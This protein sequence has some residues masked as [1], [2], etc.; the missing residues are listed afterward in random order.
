MLLFILV[1][2]WVRVSEISTNCATDPEGRMTG[3]DQRR[4]ETET[5]AALYAKPRLW[6]AKLSFAKGAFR[7]D[8]HQGFLVS[9][10]QPA[11]HHVAGVSSWETLN[12]LLRHFKTEALGL[13]TFSWSLKLSCQGTRITG[14]SSG[15]V[16]LVTCPLVL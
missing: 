5:R 14:M 8:I 13:L 1:N 4:R 10:C 2:P 11:V 7:G 9:K 6:A 16:T 12:G 15:V 3:F